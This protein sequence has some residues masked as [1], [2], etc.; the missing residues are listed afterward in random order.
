MGP[1]SAVLS[2]VL[3]VDEELPGFPVPEF[4]LL[5]ETE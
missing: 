5:A 4:V 1:F 3:V 2:P